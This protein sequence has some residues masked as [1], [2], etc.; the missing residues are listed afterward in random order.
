MTWFTENSIQW[1]Y[2]MFTTYGQFTFKEQPMMAE[3]HYTKITQHTTYLP[4]FK[5]DYASQS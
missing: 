2:S 5:L 3:W 4:L 1:R